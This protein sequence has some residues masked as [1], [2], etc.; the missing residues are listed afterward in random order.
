MIDRAKSQKEDFKTIVAL[1]RKARIDFLVGG[2]YAFRDR[3]EHPAVHLCGDL[4]FLIPATDMRRASQIVAELGY[5]RDP[6]SEYGSSNPFFFKR[7][8]WTISLYVSLSER[9]M[10][11]IS[12]GTRRVELEGEAFRAISPE[13]LALDYIANL[14]E[15]RGKLLFLLKSCQIDKFLMANLIGQYSRLRLYEK[16]LRMYE[17]EDEEIKHH[18]ILRWIFG[19]LQTSTVCRIYARLRDGSKVASVFFYLSYSF[20]RIVS[21]VRK[22]P[23][24]HSFVILIKNGPLRGF[25]ELV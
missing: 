5:L 25:S 11:H 1:F 21:D 19:Q 22:T 16:L 14:P 9:C 15:K 2:V 3:L 24:G 4:D 8:P 18:G 7:G 17:N 13:N 12:L 20:L 10:D 23:P 6:D